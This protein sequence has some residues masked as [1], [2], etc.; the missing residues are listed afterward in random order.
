MLPQ[1][2]TAVIESTGLLVRLPA[3]ET[4]PAATIGI[5]SRARLSLTPLAEHVA[6]LV[7]RAAIH[8]AATLPGSPATAEELVLLRKAPR[9][10][11]APAPT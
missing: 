1:Q 9:S 4:L 2:W 10:T 11:G 6:D 5:V 3:R 8:H 7:R